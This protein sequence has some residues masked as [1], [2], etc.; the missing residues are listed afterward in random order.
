MKEQTDFDKAI[1]ECINDHCYLKMVKKKTPAKKP[2]KIPRFVQNIIE[3]KKFQKQYDTER[4]VK[5][6]WG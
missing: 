3:D 2:N 6:C 4:V 1:I 5:R